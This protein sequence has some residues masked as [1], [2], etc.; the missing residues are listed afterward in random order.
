MARTAICSSH[1]KQL[2]VIA[3]AALL[4][5]VATVVHADPVPVGQIR[6]DGLRNH[7][8]VPGGGY[9]GEFLVNASQLNFTPMGLGRNGADASHFVSF[10][11]E[12]TEYLQLKTWYDA[13]LNTE[14]RNTYR[15]VQAETAYLYSHFIRGDLDGYKYFDD[16]SASD[17]EKAASARA[18]QE[19]I[20]FYQDP[21]GF[22][23]RY[24]GDAFSSSGYF[25]GTA[26]H[27]VLARSWYSSMAAWIQDSGPE[28][29]NVRILNLWESGNARQDTLVMIPLPAPIWLGGSGLFLVGLAGAVARRR[30]L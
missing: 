20:W 28:L 1:R 13:D 15:T 10:C 9:A 7:F 29:S 23:A 3:A 8:A 21:A 4:G 27:K 30:R 18:L 26:L 5:A 19:V 17:T 6:M 2:S 24:G 12:T 25:K 22:A 11:V 14:S 16:A